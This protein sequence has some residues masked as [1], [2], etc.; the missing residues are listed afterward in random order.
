MHIT[1][2]SVVKFRSTR[3]A[4]IVVSAAGLLAGGLTGCGVG[5]VAVSKA[6]SVTAPGTSG[7]NAINSTPTTTS[8]SGTAGNGGSNSATS[9]STGSST[10]TTVVVNATKQAAVRWVTNFGDSI[11]GGWGS[12]APQFAYA[13][14]LDTAIASPNENLARAGDQAADMARLWVYPNA[15]SSPGSSQLYTVLI[16][17]NDAYACGGSDGCIENW[18][19]S[20]AASLAWMAVPAGDK[21]LGNS[22]VEHSGN[23]SPDLKNG[24]ATYAEGASLS[25]NMRQAVSGRSLLV[26]Y[27]VFDV[28]AGGGAATVRIDGVPVTTLS[29][30]V[31]T[32]RAIDTKNGTSDTI[33]LAMIPL[34]EEGE[35][36]ITLT[37][38]TAGFFSL[39]WAGVSS[40]NYAQVAGAPRVLIGQITSTGSAALNV[41]VNQYNAKLQQ[42]ITAL[43]DEGLNIQIVPTANVLTPGTDFSD[44]LHPNDAGHLVLAQTFAASL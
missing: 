17:T 26:A 32:G 18:R 41:T 34:G 25:F 11:T 43:A 20:L 29:A 39:Q 5:A 40:G 12:S 7:N 30:E 14:L 28:G 6:A 44:E 37:T 27:R 38:T 8:S 24:I 1:R 13:S 10:G 9:S 35:H 22:I 21:V 23:W 33:F 15:T 2:S 36:T 42:L 19:Q 4:L 31:D 16:G 3:T